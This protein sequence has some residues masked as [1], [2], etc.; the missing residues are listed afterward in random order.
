MIISK[1]DVEYIYEWDTLDF[2]YV[3]TN[4]KHL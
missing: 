4:A 2:S 1:L 3:I